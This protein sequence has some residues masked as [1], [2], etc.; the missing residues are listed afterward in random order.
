VDDLGLDTI[1]THLLG[2]L[3][4]ALEHS[5]LSAPLTPTR[6]QVWNNA[7]S[8][9]AA[10]QLEAVRQALGGEVT[11]L[12]VVLRLIA[13]EYA[14][15]RVSTCE[16]VW[17]GPEVGIAHARDTA[18]VARE[19]F[20]KATTSV[21]VATYVVYQGQDIFAALAKQMITYPDLEVHLVLN[22]SKKDGVEHT[23]RSFTQWMWP[24]QAPRPKVY[25]DPRSLEQGTHSISMHAKCIVVDERFTLV[26]SANFTEAAH[27]RN[28]EAGALIDDPAYARAMRAQ[29]EDLIQ[30]NILI[31]LPLP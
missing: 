22:V 12:A 2:A 13:G 1:P 21:L 23:A 4:D 10:N 30:H 15:R 5:A 6:V 19:L 29:F 27:R 24:K 8:V 17:T 28:I 31:E 16:L 18:V 11:S 25:Y 7:L 14:R 26:T 3:A 9:Q 20:S